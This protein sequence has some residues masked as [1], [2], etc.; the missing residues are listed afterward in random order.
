MGLTPRRIMQP[1]FVLDKRDESL[2]VTEIE[3]K[4]ALSVPENT[5]RR[6]LYKTLLVSGS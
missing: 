5:G 6:G 3:R 1:I 4:S 2:G